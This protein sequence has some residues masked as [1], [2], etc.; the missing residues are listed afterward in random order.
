MMHS[1]LLL[2]PVLLFLPLLAFMCQVVFRLIRPCELAELPADWLENFDPSTYY[3]MRGLLADDDFKFLSRQPGYD[4]ALHRKFR[5]DRLKIFRQYLDS[6][7]VDFNRLHRL[8]VIV[9]SKTEGDH[10]H[11]LTRLIR[12]RISFSLTVFQ[13][14]FC[15]LLCRFRIRSMSV[16]SLLANLDEMAAQLTSLRQGNLPASSY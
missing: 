2:T 6:L 16:S 10:S 5:Q 7:I 12:L 1:A 15:Y 11:L 8:A 9:V 13:V 3:P 4:A 14:E